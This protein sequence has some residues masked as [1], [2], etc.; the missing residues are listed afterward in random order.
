MSI[1][2]KQP[3][4]TGIRSAWEALDVVPSLA[5][6]G[7][8]PMSPCAFGDALLD[9]IDSLL[10]DQDVLIGFWQAPGE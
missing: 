2:G 1:W 5:P 3:H 7:D 10:D 6:A 4:P 8:V 9:Q